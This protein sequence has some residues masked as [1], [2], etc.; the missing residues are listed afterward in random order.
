M[1]VE[2][3]RGRDHDVTSCIFSLASLE[4]LNRTKLFKW[5]T[6]MAAQVIAAVHGIV[7]DNDVPGCLCSA[8]S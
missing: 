5:E 7:K 1:D 6:P 4:A 2:L 8:P 3:C